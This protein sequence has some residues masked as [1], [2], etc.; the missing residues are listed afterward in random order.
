MPKKKRSD[1]PVRYKKLRDNSTVKSA[2]K[3][4]ARVFGLPEKCVVIKQRNGR[5]A[6][7][8]KKIGAVR[9]DWA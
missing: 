4:I 9:E 6:R 7:T 5:K 3:Q 1:K 8:D 2:T